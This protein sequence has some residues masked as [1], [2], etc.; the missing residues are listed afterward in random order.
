MGLRHYTETAAN[1]AQLSP[2]TLVQRALKDG[3]D[4]SLPIR[5]NVAV[6]AAAIA[7]VKCN[8]PRRILRGIPP[9]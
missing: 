3:S 6:E 7:I 5:G 9:K 2:L 1:A 8:A 4:R